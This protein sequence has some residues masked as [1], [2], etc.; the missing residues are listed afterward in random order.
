MPQP[1]VA[2]AAA[3]VALVVASSCLED[4]ES[5]SGNSGGGSRVTQQRSVRPDYP[6]NDPVERG[7]GLPAEQL[8]RIWRGYYRPTSEDV[9]LVPRKPAFFGSVT[10]VNHSGP[11]DF[12]QTVP[13]VFFGPRTIAAAGIVD[14]PVTLADVYPTIGELTGVELDPRDGR[15]LSEV[16]EPNTGVRPK[17]VVTIVWD[18]VG[19]NVLDYWS[20]KWPTLSRLERK[21]TSYR[22]A[23][24]ASSPSITPATHATLGTGTWPRHHHVTGIYMR[25]S[26]GL[27][28]AFD[29]TDPTHLPISTFA[30]QIDVALDNRPKVGLLGWSNWHLPMMGHGLAQRGGDLDDVG[31]LLLGGNATGNASYFSLPGYLDGFPGLLRQA[32]RLDRADG[33]ADGEWMGRDILAKTDNPAWVSYQTDMLLAMLAREDYG[34]D[35]V[36]DFMF[37]N[38]KMS[39]YVGHQHQFESREMAAV[40]RAQDKALGRLVDWLGRRVRDYVVVVTA[41][42]GHTPNPRRSGGWPIGQKEL[43][44]D[45]DD[46]FDVSDGSSLVERITAVG[47]FLD[48]ATLGQTDVTASEVATFVN[49][50]TIGQNDTASKSEAAFKGRA[51]EQLFAAAWPGRQMSAV[52]RCKFGSARPTGDAE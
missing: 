49:G 12:L 42:H 24:V 35:K 29:G 51:G 11:W 6:S 8:A 47:I 23:T 43:K 37:V 4:R 41:D 3:V 9:L 46:Y 25:G 31:I 13:L 2:V 45:I 34:S 36:A 39:D 20:Q 16:A 33:K 7:C 5:P 17:L 18:G 40:L 10:V 14:D 38:Y 22:K 1:R 21:G 19:R 15:A 27:D 50:Y 30:D 48:R 26:E 52:M 44:Y 32:D 28:L